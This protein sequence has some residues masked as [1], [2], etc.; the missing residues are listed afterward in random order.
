MRSKMRV[1][2]ELV[3]NGM[4]VDEVLAHLVDLTSEGTVIAY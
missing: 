2:F 1:R 3:A 4:G